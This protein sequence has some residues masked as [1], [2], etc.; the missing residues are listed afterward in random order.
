MVSFVTRIPAETIEQC[1]DWS[2]P[3][4]NSKNTVS[5]VKGEKNNIR[6]R[7]LEEREKAKK[8]SEKNH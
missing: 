8:I 1:D 5:A 3:S 2:L 7:V 4:V 6:R